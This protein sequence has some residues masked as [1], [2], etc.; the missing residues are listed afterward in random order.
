MPS[1]EKSKP[2]PESVPITKELFPLDQGP[3]DFSLSRQQDLRIVSAADVHGH[4]PDDTYLIIDPVA[5]DPNKQVGFT[6][7]RNGE[8]VI[9]GRKHTHGRF[10][11]VPEVSAR[12][13]RI[14]RLDGYVQIEDLNSTNGTFHLPNGIATVNFAMP[15]VELDHQTSQ[16]KEHVL[17]IAAAT[18]ASERH[19]LRNEDAYFSDSTARIA[20]VLDGMGSRDGSELAAQVG[21]KSLSESLRNTPTKLNR[22]VAVDSVRHA[23]I[24]AHQDIIDSADPKN[25]I[26]AT[27]AVIKLFEDENGIEFPVIAHAGD[28]RIYRMRNGVIDMLTLDHAIT[29]GF[30]LEE[31]IAIQK[32]LA[33]ATSDE[34]FSQG[35][36]LGF[37]RREIIT[38]SLSSSL[39]DK[40]IVEAVDLDLVPGDRY[41]LTTDGI[42]DNLTTDEI[43][44]VLA[45]EPDDQ[46]AV[47]EL[48]ENSRAR[49]R[50]KLL[51]DGHFRAKR[52]DM[53][54]VIL[55]Y[56][57]AA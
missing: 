41:L 26:G 6:P 39:K 43:A 28:S 57:K 31:Q 51:K 1:H 9:L 15:N 16:E 33:N 21:A 36:R 29:A 35:E 50:E 17:N 20:G 2:I 27:A 52:D 24:K 46:A 38:N 10:A 42:T 23:F 47:T 37:N 48:T 14:R 8:E 40:L 49:G 19:P 44:E 32:K 53:T 34:G 12:H 13:A 3:I 55:S 45:K 22:K 4:D 11:F 56:G 7:I 25:P 54:A 5:F 30:P 18:L